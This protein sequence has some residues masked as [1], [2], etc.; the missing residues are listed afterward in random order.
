MAER[1]GGVV[2]GE[3][4]VV[5][6]ALGPAAGDEA[7]ARLEPQPHLAGDELLRVRR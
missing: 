4:V 7:A 1:V 5:E 3:V 2:G 6:A